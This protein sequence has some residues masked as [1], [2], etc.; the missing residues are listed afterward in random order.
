MGQNLKFLSY[1]IVLQTNSLVLW[2]Y[3][4]ILKTNAFKRKSEI[5]SQIPLCI[6]MGFC[7]CKC[8]SVEIIRERKLDRVTS[9]A[10]LFIGV[11]ALLQKLFYL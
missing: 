1:N 2:G 3:S 7:N 11:V 5:K 4:L 6:L 10:F 8:Y 9:E